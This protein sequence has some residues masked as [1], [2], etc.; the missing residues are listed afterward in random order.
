MKYPYNREYQFEIRALGGF[1][2]RF[3]L[4]VRT[5]RE[6]GRFCVHVL[7]HKGRM[8][9][10]K[11]TLG[12]KQKPRIMLVVSDNDLSSGAFR[13][14]VNMAKYINEA[15][16]YEV[17]AVLPSSASGHRLFDEAGVPYV[18][19]KSAPWIIPL[20]VTPKSKAYDLSGRFYLNRRAIPQ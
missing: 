12:L 3:W 10:S 5:V 4:I 17:F 2:L 7:T 14:A 16:R 18:T 13:C 19:V 6:W 11:V 20:G 8:P 1:G 15:G 9:R